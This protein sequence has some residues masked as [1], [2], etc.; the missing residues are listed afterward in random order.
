MLTAVHTTRSARIL[1]VFPTPSVSHQ[2]VY[3]PIWKEL[4]LRGHAVTVLTP[5]PLQDPQLTNL[6]EID[7][8]FMYEN[9][10]D[11]SKIIGKITHWDMLN[12]VIPA[13]DNLYGKILSHPDV[14]SMLNNISVHFDL[15][16][17]EFSQP[18]VSAFAYKYKCPLIGVTSMGVM[19]TTHDA[20]GNP[21]H[22]ILHP[23]FLLPLDEDMSFFEKIEAVLF[24]LRFKYDYYNINLP[25]F[26]KFARRFFGEDMPYLGDLERNISLLFLNTNRV[27]HGARPYPPK[28]MEL[29][30]MHIA[31]MKPLPQV[32]LE[33]VI[34]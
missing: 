19:S 28:V 15:V 20:V 16:I 22:P 30:R 21:A 5:S 6:M 23:D 9:D 4:S 10:I 11:A 25:H 34:K 24:A 17:A 26:D 31:P 32:R 29:G 3:Q 12:F 7:L 18:T 1:G 27:I 8:S 33:L 13:H 2:I 14:N